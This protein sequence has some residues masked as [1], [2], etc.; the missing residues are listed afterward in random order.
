MDFI[1]AM[2]EIVKDSSLVAFPTEEVVGFSKPFIAYGQNQLNSGFRW[3]GIYLAVIPEPKMLFGD[4]QVC[5]KESEYCLKPEPGFL[6]RS[7]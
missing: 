6:V 5:K 7:D 1:S 3:G 2:E 4:W